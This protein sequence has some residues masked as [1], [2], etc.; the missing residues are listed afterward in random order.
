MYRRT[1][2]QIWEAEA[3]VGHQVFLLRDLELEKWRELRLETQFSLLRQDL[4]ELD[5]PAG[6]LQ[7]PGFDS[8]RGRMG[9]VY[10]NSWGLFRFFVEYGERE[11]R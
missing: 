7:R 10:R 6:F 4:E 1:A 9:L 8:W 11:L 5:R 2:S 3:S